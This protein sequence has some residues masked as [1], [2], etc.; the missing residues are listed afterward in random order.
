MILKQKMWVLAVSFVVLAM[1][2]S[3]CTAADEKELNWTGRPFD[4]T[5]PVGVERVV[6]F[7]A[8]RIQVAFPTD[9]WGI[10]TAESSQGVVYLRSSRP[11][12]NVRVRFRNKDTGKI[13][14]LNVSAVSDESDLTPI[15]I[16]D[17]AANDIDNSM[18]PTSI[19]NQL[20]VNELGFQEVQQLPSEVPSAPVANVPVEEPEPVFHG[21]TTLVRYAMQNVYAP[22]RLIEELDDVS[23]I[24]FDGEERDIK[25]VPGVSV[26][27]RVLG[28]WR[29][30]DRYVTAVYLQNLTDTEVEL[31][32]RILIGRQY[33]DIAALMHGVLQPAN[34]Y[35]DSTTLVAISDRKWVEYSQWLR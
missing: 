1:S 32:P 21:V 33:W 9:L 15:R 17:E 11:F 28:Q 10:A 31:D 24:S 13:Y 35:G 16:I 2:L 3:V 5:I 23:R 30:N 12:E 7:N 20:P 4:I 18:V 26:K 27:S 29:N 22:D 34:T 19:D 8:K 14:S 6:K 25:V